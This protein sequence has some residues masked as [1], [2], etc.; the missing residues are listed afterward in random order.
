M[1]KTAP[2]TKA[3]KPLKGYK[4][5]QTMQDW[6]VD[7][8]INREGVRSKTAVLMSLPVFHGSPLRF[9]STSAYQSKVGEEYLKKVEIGL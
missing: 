7:I 4:L 3:D 2:T 8:E 5:E 6:L 1:K 9:G